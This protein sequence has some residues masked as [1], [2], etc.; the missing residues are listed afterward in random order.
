MPV[1]YI[2]YLNSDVLVEGPPPY[3]DLLFIL[4]P[5]TSSF[6]A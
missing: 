4:L 1:I 2:S 3:T 5:L 6:A